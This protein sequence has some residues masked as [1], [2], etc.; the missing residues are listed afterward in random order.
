MFFFIDELHYIRMNIN[1]RYL[2]N[3]NDT[4]G[5]NTFHFLSVA[6]V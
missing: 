2:I 3:N 6:V 1:K 4:P 5:G